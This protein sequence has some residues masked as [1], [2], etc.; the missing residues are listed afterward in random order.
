MEGEVDILEADLAN[1]TTKEFLER[2]PAEIQARYQDIITAKLDRL[3][4]Y[5]SILPA[6]DGVTPVYIATR[7]TTDKGQSVLGM[8][9]ILTELLGDSMT[10][11]RKYTNTFANGLLV[12]S[13]YLEETDTAKIEE[14]TKR[15]V[16]CSLIPRSSM[17][18]TMD[19]LTSGSLSANEYA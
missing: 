3:S 19:L 4:P 2:R 9:R 7:M 1:V 12:H 6:E 8:D 15:A 14:F 18:N 10:C 11:T 17:E 13:L 5:V 16:T